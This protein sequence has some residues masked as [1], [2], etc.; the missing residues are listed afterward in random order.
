MRAALYARFSTDRQTESSIEDQYRVCAEW[1]ARNDY[2]VVARFEDQG[3][4]GAAIGN[5][6]GLQALL[7][8]AFDVIAVMDLSRLSRSQGDLPKI[9]DRLVHRG[10][11][12]VGVQDGY[13]G[14]R[15]GHKLQCGL[16]GIIGEAF[17]E[18]CSEK[19]YSALESR[20]LVGRPAGGRSYGFVPAAHNGTEHIRI[21]PAQAEVVRRIFSMFADG[22]SAKRIAE[23][24]NAEG[25]PSPGSAWSR[26]TRRRGGW[27]AS[28]IA[29]DSQRGLG[30]LRNEAYIGRI[31]WNRTRWTKDPDSGMRRST[32]RPRSEWIVHEVPELRIIDD[33]LWNRV[34]ARQHRRAH[35]VGDRVRNGIAKSVGRGPRYLLTSILKCKPC[36]SNYVMVNASHYGCSG[37][38]NGRVC[39][40]DVMADRRVLEDK[41]LTAIKQDL[42]SDASIEAFKTKIRRALLKPSTN[43]PRIAAL[44]VEISNLTDAIATGLRSSSVL[45]RL[46]AAEA[47]L[48]KLKDEEV[49][50]DAAA[51]MAAIPAAVARYRA[52]VED[53]GNAPIDIGAAREVLKEMVGEIR[54][55]PE[56]N[57]GLVAEFGL[58]ETPIRA[59]VGGKY[60]G[61]VAGVGFEPTTFGL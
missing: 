30:I 6:P 49:V 35:E 20:A 34:K 24:L 46:E 22:F 18:M 9:I 47:E 13:D 60:I 28:A 19:T 26:T 14:A 55:R 54:L 16:S 29:G 52:M 58:S 8:G 45:R 12:I 23:I 59:A 21:D 48:Q 41:L 40:N 3:I 56:P 39:A 61:L 51:V 1:C 15:K 36:G 43:G 5:R 10:A 31:T 2:S 33:Q 4:S 11:R 57:R 37:Y 32:Q 27:A 44:E 38:V 42:L 17:R 7:A 53:L 25:V 50:V